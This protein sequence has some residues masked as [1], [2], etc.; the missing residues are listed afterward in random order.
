SPSWN[1]YPDQDTSWL[2]YLMPY[3][4]LQNN[5]DKLHALATPGTAGKPGLP[6]TGTY[7][8]GTPA[9]YD[10]TNSTWIPGIPGKPGTPG[11][12]GKPAK[13]E[14]QWQQS[15]DFNGHASFGLVQVILV[16][17]VPGT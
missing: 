7:I 17:A 15:T 11:T 10:Y 5:Y 12:P 3:L 14:W 1:P 6:A 9:V 13:T 8:P 16:P 2:V 4:E